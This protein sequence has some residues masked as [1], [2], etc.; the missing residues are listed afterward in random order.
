[1][2]NQ[3]FKGDFTKGRPCE[4]WTQKRLQEEADALEKWSKLAG[5]LTLNGFSINRP[6]PYTK[7][8]MYELAE[9][10]KVLS[11]SIMRAR[12]RIA[13]RREKGGL[14]GTLDSSIVRT[15]L[16]LYDPEVKEHLLEMRRSEAE[17]AASAFSA[18]EIKKAYKKSKG[19][20]AD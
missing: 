16:P 19:S 11:D 15:G 10:S 6:E 14:H 17:A 8:Q 13:D 5:S 18:E 4:K 3:F 7:Q 2:A 9:K 1:M 20:D 12:Q